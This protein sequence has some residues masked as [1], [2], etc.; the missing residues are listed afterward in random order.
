LSFHTD[1][2]AA[3]TDADVLWVTFDTPVNEQDEADVGF[4]RARLEEV[5]PALKPGTLVLI[6][7]QVPVGFTR[8]LQRDWPDGGLRFA[9]SPE[10]LRLGKAIEVF[11]HPERVVLGIED[12]ADRTRLTEL[13][14]PFCSHLE[15]MTLESAEM[16]KHALN[17]FLATSVTFINEVARLCEEV[18]ANAKEVERGLKSE[19]RIGPR[20]YLSPGAAFAGG[21]LAR[22]LRFLVRRGREV[23]V[24]TPLLQGVLESNEVHKNWVREH[25]EQLLDGI[26]VPVATVLGLTYKPGTSTLRRSSAIELCRWMHE[27]GVRVRGYDPAVPTLP[28]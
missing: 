28:D 12:D 18:G 21:T 9:Y 25:V 20:A 14:S 19:G 15:W 11:C 5:R 8:A 13:F 1:P 27:R 2:A 16:T 17:A 22:D 6:S 10:N 7:S 3:L 24:R 4:V 26:E 23:Q